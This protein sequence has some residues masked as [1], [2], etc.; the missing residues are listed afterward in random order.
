MRILILKLQVGIFSRRMNFFWCTGVCGTCNRIFVL[1]FFPTELKT[2]L[3]FLFVDFGFSNLFQ[4][5]KH[6][7]TWCGSPP[8]AAPE[9]FEG[10]AYC[11]PEVD[12]W[13]SKTWHIKLCGHG[14]IFRAGWDRTAF[15]TVLDTGNKK[16]RLEIPVITNYPNKMTWP[17]QLSTEYLERLIEGK[18]LLS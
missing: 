8:Y 4:E 15:R 7:K 13:V 1:F 18:L 16:E 14:Y 6:L 10:K 5:G 17:Q 12:I 2:T 9:L 11:G 3:L